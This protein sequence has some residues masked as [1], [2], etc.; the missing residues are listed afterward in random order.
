MKKILLFTLAYFLSASVQAQ[1]S[2]LLKV[3]AYVRH[4]T[5]GAVP[6]VVASENGAPIKK[7]ATALVNYSIYVELKKG[8]TITINRLWIDGKAFKAR[9]ETVLET[10]VVFKQAGIGNQYQTD[11]L[12][13]KTNNIVWKLVQDGM[14][15]Q[16]QK[17]PKS[18]KGNAL[19]VEYIWKGKKFYY[20]VKE[21]KKLPPL[22]LQ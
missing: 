10:P 8:T 9:K 13:P 6:K 15:N 7:T 12:V 1:A 5:P 14:I 11:T 2:P 16:S 21:W 22:I 19:L 4:S 3:H 17:P 18:L 20:A